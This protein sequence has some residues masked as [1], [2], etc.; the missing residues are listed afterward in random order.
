MRFAGWWGGGYLILELSALFCNY[1][2]LQKL[3]AAPN[4]NCLRG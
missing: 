4:S 1:L 3:N 2:R